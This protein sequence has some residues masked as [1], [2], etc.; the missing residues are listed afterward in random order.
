MKLLAMD[1]SLTNAGVCRLRDVRA[2]QPVWD[3]ETVRV[4]LTRIA[5]ARPGTTKAGAGLKGVERLVWWYLWLVEEI[6][7]GAEL[8]VLEA[9]I[10]HGTGMHS[11]I[12]ELMGAIKLTAHQRDIPVKMVAVSQIKKW[13]TGSGA[14]DKQRMID[15]AT[16]AMGGELTLDEHQ[17]D[18]YWLA[19]LSWATWGE[20]EPDTP[21]RTLLAKT[22]RGTK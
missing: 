2:G 14:A 15:T 17:A 8:I 18:A 12:G 11:D 3:I 16:E 4:P 6:A 1:L 9:P 22:L 21:S 7:D 5:G 19:H 20:G 10:L 13:A